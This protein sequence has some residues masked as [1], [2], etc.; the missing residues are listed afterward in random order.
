MYQKPIFST[1]ISR[2][3]VVSHFGSGRFELEQHAREGRIAG[4]ITVMARQSN[5]GP[6]PIWVHLAQGC[7]H[8]N[9]GWRRD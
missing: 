5:E 8:D 3:S 1:R 4:A 2:F 7:G 6:F 9:H